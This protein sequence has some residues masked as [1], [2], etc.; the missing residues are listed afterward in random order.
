MKIYENKKKIIK[1]LEHQCK[2]KNTTKPSEAKNLA[3]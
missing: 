3:P 2:L 1:I